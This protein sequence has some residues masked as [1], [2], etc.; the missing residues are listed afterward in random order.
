M[1]DIKVYKAG[2]MIHDAVIEDVIAGLDQL[3]A[4]LLGSLMDTP[5]DTLILEV[6][7][8]PGIGELKVGLA[9]SIVTLGEGPKEMASVNTS[10]VLFR[11]T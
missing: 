5:E 11:T 3:E 7:G 10:V 4:A 8:F 6:G 2:P 1:P 9:L